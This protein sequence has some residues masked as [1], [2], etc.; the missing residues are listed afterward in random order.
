MRPSTSTQRPTA[1]NRDLRTHLSVTLAWATAA[2]AGLALLSLEL[3][4]ANE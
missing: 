1:I 2:F 3:A 4:G